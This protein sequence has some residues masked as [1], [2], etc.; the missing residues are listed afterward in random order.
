MTPPE[1][2]KCVSCGGD[3]S[4]LDLSRAVKC[5]ACG[6]WVHRD[7]Y[8]GYGCATDHAPKCRLDLALQQVTKTL[9]EQ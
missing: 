4:R 5:K 3:V 8:Q 7:Y 9:G 2:K 1:E 6:K